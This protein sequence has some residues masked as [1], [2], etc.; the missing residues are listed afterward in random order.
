M[1]Y[2]LL[3]GYPPVHVNVVHT[4]MRYTWHASGASIFSLYAVTIVGLPVTSKVNPPGN[5]LPSRTCTPF[6]GRLDYMHH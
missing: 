6:R 5:K 1:N 4:V 3:Q 2:V